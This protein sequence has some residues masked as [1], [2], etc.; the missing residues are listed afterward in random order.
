[1]DVVPPPASATQVPVTASPPAATSGMDGPIAQPPAA[2]AAPVAQAP[3]VSEVAV[4]PDAPP[5]EKPAAHAAPA[6]P[7]PPRTFPIGVVVVAS[8]VFLVLSVVAYYA[9]STG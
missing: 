6:K 9:Y 5:A 4:A 3:D 2:E 1:M 7:K 8:I